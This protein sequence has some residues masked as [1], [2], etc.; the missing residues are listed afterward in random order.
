MIRLSVLLVLLMVLAGY[1]Y[2]SA[3]WKK[4]ELE[5]SVGAHTTL[6][7]AVSGLMMFFLSA[8]F[9]MACKF[10]GYDSQLIKFSADLLFPYPEAFSDVT[11]AAIEI[12]LLAVGLAKIIPIFILWFLD[13]GK[14]S[15]TDL[16]CDAFRNS[17]T[18]SEFAEILFES[19]SAG[20]PVLFTMKD[21]K[22]YVGYP[23]ELK[24]ANFNDIQ[25]VP[26][27]SGYRDKDTLELKLTVPYE[28]V[29]EKMQSAD[30]E[31]D[32]KQFLVSMPLREISHAHLFDFQKKNLFDQQQNEFNERN[33]T[34]SG[35]A[36]A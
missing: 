16:A 7:C 13:D 6:I 28:M 19:L 11:L 32:I 3:P 30:T 18:K 36:Q 35:E 9:I 20:M 2:N 10:M 31:F 17:S 5:Q 21:K 8:C 29:I 15:A 26:V 22:V 27:Y 34:A 33:I 14:V 23:V 25:I 12:G 24:Y 1:I 4:Y